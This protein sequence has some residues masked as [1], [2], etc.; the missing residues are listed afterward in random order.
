MRSIGALS[1][2]LAIP[3]A[4]NIEEKNY[5]LTKLSGE[6]IKAS[7]PGDYNKRVK[8]TR[9]IDTATYILPGELFSR[10]LELSKDSDARI[11]VTAAAGVMLLLNRYT[12]NRQEDIA[13][14]TAIYR[15]EKDHD[16]INTV[17][18]L[19]NQV[20]PGTTFKEFLIQVGQVIREANLYQNYPIEAL[21]QL[22]DMSPAADEDFPLFDTAVIM[23]NLH[24]KKYLSHIHFNTLF[25]FKRIDAGMEVTVEY[26]SLLYKK[27]TIERLVSHYF[28]LL[29]NA[30]SNVN[31]Q[32]FEIDIL[33][34]KE[35][36]MILFEFNDTKAGYSTEK[37][38]HQ[39]FEEQAAK[40]PGNMAVICGDKS[41]TY[42]R[43]NQKANQLA[44]EL[45]KRGL[46]PN[47]F[48]AVIIDRSIEM[49]VGVMAILKAG[50]AYVP[51]EPYL[52]GARIITSLS[53]L[54]VE[55][56][57]TNRLQ[58]SM[59]APLCEQ[60]AGLKYVFCLDDMPEEKGIIELFK[61]KELILPPQL[62][63]SPAEN[64]LPAAGPTDIAYV[65]FTSG[66]T[67][68]PKGV[69]LKHQPVINI[70]QWVNKTY[71]VNSSDKLLF[72][73][74]LS[75][76]LS[77]YDIFGILASGAVI[78]LADNEEIKSPERLV[79]IIFNEGITF[80]DSAPAALQML[81]PYLQNLTE[82]DLNSIKSKVRLI[83]LSGDWIPVA[84]P[85]I[86]KQ[87]FPGV[88]VISLG[89][90]TEAAIWSNFYPID[91]VAPEWISIPYGKPI[92]NAKYYILDQFLNPTPIGVPGDLYIGGECL[93][94]G[95]INDDALTANKFIHNPFTP[96]EKMYKTGDL[97]RWFPD[98]NMEF[99][100]RLDNQVK[101]RGYRV[102]LGDIESQLLKHD[103]I[104]EV[105]VTAREGNTEAKS[106]KY[107]CAYYVSPREFTANQLADYLSVTL[108]EYMI[109]PYFV[110]LEKM[111]VTPNG[112]LDRKALPAP[113]FTLETQEYIAP[114]SQVEQRIVGIWSQLL[115]IEKEKI[116][117]NANFFEMGGH[118]L[119]ATVLIA[120]L[121]KEL[122]VK[123]PLMEIFTKPTINAL[124][125]YIDGAVK[126]VFTAIQPVEKKERYPLSSAQKRLYILQQ[127]EIESTGYNLPNVV[128]FSEGIE[129]DK[130][131]RAFKK[132]IQRHESFR[133]FF[134]MV[135]EVPVQGIRNQVEFSVDYR[136]ITG[137]GGQH[138]DETLQAP[139]EGNPVK[140]IIKSFRQPFDLSRAPLLR[141]TLIKIENKKYI[142]LFD[143]HHIITDGTSEGI[144]FSEFM[145]L[146]AGNELPPLRLQYKDYAGWQ[147]SAEQQEIIK[148]QEEYWLQL[149]SD[150][151]TVLNFP[152]DYPRPAIQSFQGERILFTIEENDTRTIKDHAGKLGVT[153]FMYILSAFNILLAKL[154]GDVDIIV[155]T[156]IAARRHDDLQRIIGMFVNTLVSR[157]YPYPGKT[158]ETFLS[159]VKEQTLRSYENQEYPFEL[160]VDKISVA[161]DTSRNPIFDMM[162]NL[163]NQDEYV[164]LHGQNQE[165]TDDY[166]EYTAKF[167][168]NLGAIDY[169]QIISFNIEYCTQL[170]KAST[171]EKIIAYFKKILL[172]L[173]ANPGQ[174]ISDIDI[175]TEKEK[176]IILNMANGVKETSAS[177][178]TIHQLYE[179][180]AK[181][182]PGKIAVV[183]EEKQITYKN[184]NEKANQMARFLQEK[185]IAPDTV[186][187][188][189][190]NRSIEMVIAIL[191]VMKAGGAYLPI[192]PQ[193]PAERITYM[194]KD[195]G[196]S[197]L[198]TD[199]PAIGNMPV[200]FLKSLNTWKSQPVI[201]ST[202]ERIYDFNSIP[203]PDRSLV[204]YKKYHKY[205]S[206]AM[207][208]HSV[209]IQSS[210]GCPFKCMYCN[211]ICTG[212][213]VQRSVENI[214]I[215]I[216]QCYEAGIRRFTFIDDVFNLDERNAS[217]VLEKLIKNKME[218]QLFF[219]NGLRGDILSKEFIDLM[220]EAGT[221]T[222]CLALETGSPRL[223]KLMKKRLNLEKFKD[224]LHY[225]TR[226][227][228]H[229]ILELELMHGFPTETEAEAMETLDYLM[230]IKWVHFPD[231]HILKIYPQTDMYRLAVKSGITE[232]QIAR[233][234]HLAYHE[235]PETL[236]F[237][238]D[239]TRGYQAK[240]LN[241]Y[242]FLKERLLQVLPY[243]VKVLTED[244]LVQKYDSYLPYDIKN[245]N[246][247]L[248]CL[249]IPGE[250]LGKVELMQNDDKSVPDFSAKMS[251]YFIKKEKAP[252][253]LR[254]LLLDLSLSF[255]TDKN[256]RLYDVVEAPLGLMYLMTYL[257]E[258][259]GEQ[260]QGKVFKS[261]ID[262]DSYEELKEIIFD[263]KPEMIGIRTLSV[264]KEFFHHTVSLIRDWGI[265]A[266]I[267]SGG[268]YASTEYN[269]MLQDDHVDIAVL[270]EGELILAQLLEETLKND[271][272]LPGEKILN[273]IP[274]I[275]FVKSRDKAKAREKNC[276]PLFMEKIA[277]ELGDYPGKNLQRINKPGDLAY[278]IYTSGSTGIPK[279]VML[280]HR[281][282]TNLIDY[283]FK[284]TNIDCS[285]ILQFHTISFDASFHEIFCALLFGGKS[286]LIE[287]ETRLNI[288]RLLE[289]VGKNKIKTLFLPMSFLRVIFGDEDY[290]KQIPGCVDHIQ[291]A[292]EQVIINEALRTYLRDNHVY[293]HNH[294]GPSETHVVTALSLHPQEE[295]PELPT[296]GKPILNIGIYILDKD[297]HLSP[298]GVPGELFA[299]G[300]Q[301][302]RGY[303][304]KPNLTREKFIPSPY[305]KGER[306]YKTGDLAKWMPDGNIEF[307]GRIDDQVKIRGF[308]VEPGEI[309]SRLASHE[310]VKEVFVHTKENEK[311]EKY[312]CA[313]IVPH[314]P[315]GTEEISLVTSRLKSYLS[316]TLPDY[317]IPSY[318][319]LLGKIPVTQNGKVNRKALPHPEIGTGADYIAPGNEIEKELAAIWAEVLAIEKTQIGI[320]SN[321]FDIGG[322]SLKA[323]IMA[324]KIHKKLN[325]K[326]PLAEIFKTPTIKGLA[327]YLTGA[328][329]IKFTPLEPVEKKEYYPVSSGQKRLYLIQQMDLNATTY[330]LP[331]MY[332][333]EDEINKNKLV[334]TFKKL[335]ERHESLRTS[336]EFVNGQP[337]Q[338]VHDHVEFEIEY[339]HPK[340]TTEALI[341]SFISPFDLSMAP[342]IHVGLLKE[343]NKHIL[344]ID[345]HHIISDGVS[346]SIL[347]KDFISLYIG[348][349]LSALRLHYK[350]FTLWQN[351]LIS[352]GEMQKQEQFWLKE[353]AGDIPALNLSLDYDKRELQ[354]FAGDEIQFE[355]SSNEANVL[356]DWSKKENATLFIIL[357][358]IYN[359]LLSK[360]S[361]QEDIIVGV[362]TAGRRHADLEKI[363][364][365]FVNTLALRNY[366]VEEKTFKE[367]LL[368]VKDRTLQAFDNQDYLFEDLVE[369]VVKKRDLSRNPLFDTVFMLQNVGDEAVDSSII[370]KFTLK[371]KPYKY[372]SN[373]SKF[374]M[375][376]S[377]TEVGES[378]QFF[379]TYRTKLFERK[380]IERY[381]SYFKTIV[382][383]VTDN[384]EIKIKDILIS[385][386][387]LRSQSYEDEM[388]LGF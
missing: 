274:G 122:N 358:A 55:S 10:L 174:K 382:S 210:R 186:V 361:G 136:D 325:V 308:R 34:E 311:R 244:E 66:T 48:V 110:R 151:L 29:K 157:N 265:D 251:K 370:E 232:E 215:E 70:I 86:L 364:G 164:N 337:I 316:Q 59:L 388:E 230:E 193:Y 332:I 67:G 368:E 3:A 23:E 292:G 21:L 301:V 73:V 137:E 217:Q 17:L 198:L 202:R 116:G 243:Q 278:V 99:L 297:G 173:P 287:N 384:R 1:G 56:L 345:M 349:K 348:E 290:I 9:R 72:I 303:L 191:A 293:L 239:F 248:D 233:S 269:V 31:S 203:I 106:D 264:Y 115:G 372:E 188:V 117:I 342:L 273:N 39:L 380:T 309:E 35:K 156:P 97:A 28:N 16:F 206:S 375:F 45:R 154:S 94:S 324:A 228:P 120:R 231:L 300:V 57:L 373:I 95:Y 272:K 75:F 41:L 247:I 339:Y 111:P 336:F 211:K 369:K 353:F 177:E 289:L 144:L 167:D 219:A 254:L 14:G 282:L 50:G 13:I 307:L 145:S 33:P 134:E 299:G 82:T 102:E 78:R 335:I 183:F 341:S 113:A 98:G 327:L 218:V 105:L 141:G 241:D 178:K 199:E 302:G 7:F 81:V 249:G 37:T 85:D 259:M 100:G 74:S 147:Q 229:I 280:G 201:T 40:T 304:G 374:D 143:M 77:V 319:V 360:L 181:E 180:K 140:Q 197:I 317:M 176:E 65:I 118:S 352:S 314:S 306:L 6:L 245:F 153:L 146:Y 121:H 54:N 107:L 27:S 246:D 149:F 42:A 49:V 276:Q 63:S 376:W 234:L 377:C 22:L 91:T 355:I 83:F 184:L 24:D 340:K 237:S 194:L 387:L 51:L 223:Q 101:I 36:E 125:Q 366:P 381:I 261:R 129:I 92:Q 38:M 89:G 43:L 329:K 216:R 25:I 139:A 379:V 258:K 271:K 212:K 236:P 12:Y 168:I 298:P 262:F 347:V 310:D 312:L 138:T 283:D 18:V 200:G 170:F 189:M 179:E 123:I 330:N 321:F 20:S 162:F 93:A 103:D 266:P 148:K 270:G 367:F 64:P 109:P 385:L 207:V 108:P 224:N 133:T 351:N 166:L 175:I 195:S 277:G 2:R 142:L 52:P 323:T 104:K 60:L 253:A 226:K 238:K 350:D 256:N 305:A 281:N 61:N 344:M 328:V 285:S 128:P 196:V 320:E 371:L 187:G 161:R 260:V 172:Y 150:D 135:N 15:Q 267:I 130:L 343:K 288:S 214:F 363:I 185:G 326:L 68:T 378:V 26:N 362:G 87:S 19:R 30:L 47:S 346:H 240:F 296:I 8:N 71:S 132:I 268:P 213:F 383:E 5:W 152:A 295:I 204:D 227:Y 205:I 315:K 58:L 4:Q 163:L 62:E 84:M 79:E 338:Y 255:T 171:I 291:T 279:G 208:K 11:F 53:S 131:E 225:I 112:K 222:I 190:V 127:L 386:Q 119:N 263:F 250:E 284:Y 126:E 322:H 46:M 294:Y 160:L 220:V 333:S 252:G 357:L 356:R 242:F 275:A 313:Y 221:T 69:V 192:D 114:S 159:E 158:F 90:A 124:S 359:V 235:I 209:S 365:M 331:E 76:D 80:W 334:E 169:G 165:T 257:N 182:N 286:V 88:T 155:G 44:W 318:F 32:V 96:G 354:D